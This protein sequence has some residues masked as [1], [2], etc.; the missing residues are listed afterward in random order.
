MK[1][2]FLHG[3]GQESSSWKN[4]I[5]YIEKQIDII[6]PSLSDLLGHKNINYINLYD[7]FSD[8]CK[9]FSEPLN[10]CGLSLGGIVALHYGIENPSKVN[11]LV[12]IGTQFKMPKTLLKFQ[13]IIFRFMPNSIF[14]KIGFNKIDF[15]NLSKSMM[16]LDF[17]ESL[18]KITCPVLIICGEKDT[19]NKRASLQLKEQLPKA[20][21]IFIENAGH[22][23]NIDT[24]EKLGKI[25]SAFFN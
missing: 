10:I 21:I 14:K 24:P 20:E 11:S 15:I 7:S 5:S 23:V 6:C 16:K 1:Y 25:L 22:E 19:A 12:L 18:N 3:L 13:N 17:R 2:I 8:Y 4:T 9:E